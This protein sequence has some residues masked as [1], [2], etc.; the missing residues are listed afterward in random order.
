VHEWMVSI[1]GF[2]TF[3]EIFVIQVT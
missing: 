2:H 3:Y 1:V